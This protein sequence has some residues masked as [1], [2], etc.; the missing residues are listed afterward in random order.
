[1]KAELKPFWLVLEQ[2][3]LRDWWGSELACRIFTGFVHQ[4]RDGDYVADSGRPCLLDLDM[5]KK[6]WETDYTDAES[7][8]DSSLIYEKKNSEWEEYLMLWKYSTHD[9]SSSNLRN[10]DEWSKEYCVRWALRKRI[11][12]P[13]LEWAIEKGYLPANIS[14]DVDIP[15]VNLNG[16]DEES[17]QIKT[18]NLLRLMSILVEMM[19]DPNKKKNFTNQT[20]L[21]EYIAEHYEPHEER[22]KGLSK[23]SLNRTFSYMNKARKPNKIA[24]DD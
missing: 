2:L 12:I 24:P 13:W 20:A 9:R 1:M 11:D 4:D 5:G 3:L 18:D 16:K 6:H 14:G 15:R 19:V 17:G 10:E 23:D 21:K 8:F 22:N 7:S